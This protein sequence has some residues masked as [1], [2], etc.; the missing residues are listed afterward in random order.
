MDLFWN[1]VCAKLSCRDGLL[2]VSF[3]IL[4][5]YSVIIPNHSITYPKGVIGRRR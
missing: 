2:V 5:I 3:G 4:N 1:Q